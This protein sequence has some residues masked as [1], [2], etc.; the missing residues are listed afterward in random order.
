MANKQGTACAQP[1]TNEAKTK[2]HIVIPYAQSLCKSTKKICSRYGIQTHF[3]GIQVVSSKAK[4][5][6]ENKSG[7]IY[8][9]QYNEEYI[10]EPLGTKNT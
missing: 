9:F 3:K 6:M 4:D 8:W 10:G 2:G 5:P 7:A 1:T